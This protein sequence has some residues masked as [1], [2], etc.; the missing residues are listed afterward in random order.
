MASTALRVVYS[1]TLGYKHNPEFLKNLAREIPDIHLHVFSEGDVSDK[2]QSSSMRAGITNLTVHPWVLF[3]DLPLMLSGADMFVAVIEPEAGIYSVPSK[4]LTY[5]G[6]GRP[7]LA[8]VPLENLS[9]RLI[10]NNNAGFAC[11]PSNELELIERAKQL[12]ADAALR[13]SMGDNGRDY[14]THAFN[15]EAIADRFLTIFAAL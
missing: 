14:A 6:I 13:K 9:A 8:L 15:I 2:L 3:K 7:V 11:P 5:L 4:V 1:G 10:Q 12:V